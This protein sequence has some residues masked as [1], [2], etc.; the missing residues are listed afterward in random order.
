MEI[1]IRGY[2]SSDA[3]EAAEIWNRIVEDGEAFPQ[4]ETLTEE[5]AEV[6]FSGQSFTGIAYDAESSEI[7]GLY[8]L[9][10]NNVGRCG[11]ICNASYAVRADRGE[12][13]LTLYGEGE[14]ARI[15]DPPVQCSGKEQYPRAPSV[16]E[17]GIC[18]AGDHSGRVPDERRTL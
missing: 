1:R 3:R 13:C 4:L 6:F 9:H 10:P 17:D 5:T 7:A 18:P 11:H 8:I 14:R 2:K 16:R 15:P 12:A